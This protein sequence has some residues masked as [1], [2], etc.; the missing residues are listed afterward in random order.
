[1][2]FNLLHSV[3]LEN[4]EEV[5]GDL[6]ANVSLIKAGSINRQIALLSLVCFSIVSLAR[7]KQKGSRIRG[8]LGYFILLFLLWC[9]SSIIWSDDTLFTAR[10][11]F[12]LGT[13]CLG[14]MAVAKRCSLRL[15]TELAFLY[16]IFTL[17]LGLGCEIGLGTFRP[18]QVE[19]RF[20][21]DMHP[22]YQGINCGM[23]TVAAVALSKI[24]KRN[25]LVF[26]VVAAASFVFM[27]LT[28]S[29][30][31]MVSA[32]VG[33][34][35]YWWLVS[36]RMR[37]FVYVYVIFMLLVSLYLAFGEQFLTHGKNMLL[38]AR[39]DSEIQT[40]T[41]RITIWEECLTYAMQKPIL[42]YGYDSFWTPERYWKIYRNTGFYVS[43]V[44]NGFLNLVLGVGVPGFCMFILV[45]GLAVKRT[46][47]LYNTT[48]MAEY[49][50]ALA[51]FLSYAA[52]MP[53]ISIQLVPYFPSFLVMAV[54][55]KIAYDVPPPPVTAPYRKLFHL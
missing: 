41:G 48:R 53:L 12:V 42:G 35:G 33:L 10:K 16:G 4:P 29:R 3:H 30:G 17:L 38:L 27:L 26:L 18:L 8:F 19:H 2:P 1:M 47:S 7:N 36:T 31:P 51:L 23:L 52:N 44:H 24:S 40:F 6:N 28:K 54:L 32:L 39:S 37:K 45:I 13:L 21:G 43:D 55:A 34:V 20:G 46:I 25:H 9:S 50:F 15:L 49:A 11:L 14:A 5:E 22:I